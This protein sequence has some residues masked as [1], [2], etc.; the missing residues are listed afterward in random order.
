MRNRCGTP[1]KLPANAAQLVYELAG[2][3]DGHVGVGDFV[4]SRPQLRRNVGA[5][6]FAEIAVCVGRVAEIGIKIHVMI[7]HATNL[8]FIG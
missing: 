1:L 5:A 2:F 7:F 6:I 3:A 4:H 8:L